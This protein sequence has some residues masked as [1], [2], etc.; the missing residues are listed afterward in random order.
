MCE[1]LFDAKYRTCTYMLI[2]FA[3]LNQLSGV[4][5]INLYSTDM[6]KTIQ[7]LDPT[8]AN[9]MLMSG[10]C[11]GTVAGPLLGKY[12]SLRTMLIGGE[13][14]LAI[15]LTLIALFSY[16]QISY[17]LLICMI[18]FQFTY[19][20]TL[21]SYFFVYVSQVGGSSI[22]SWAVFWIWLGVLMVNFMTQPLMETFTLSG[23]F[24]L[25]SVFSLAASLYLKMCMRCT[26]G[27]SKEELKVL[28]Y[29]ENMKARSSRTEDDDFFTVQ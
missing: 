2:I 27:L 10:A 8:L 21:G 28:Y 11:F 25:F 22:N 12:F 16:Y 13:F 3:L 19:Q 24:A 18:L 26:Q 23:L 4:N 1:V 29:P 6:L 20:T 14:A 17:G 7:G 5:A 9:Y 15:E